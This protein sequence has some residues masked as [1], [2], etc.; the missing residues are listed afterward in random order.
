MLCGSSANE[1]IAAADSGDV[2]STR[3]HARRARRYTLASWWANTARGEN[4]GVDA[5]AISARLSQFEPPKSAAI[6]R[7][8]VV[9]APHIARSPLT[10]L[11][12]H[13]SPTYPSPARKRLRSSRQAM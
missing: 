12:F 13:T 8:L 1:L 10:F 9:F 2:R 3:V 6:V 7:P 5:A 4:G 11:K